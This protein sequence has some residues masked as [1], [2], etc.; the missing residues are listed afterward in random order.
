MRT[1]AGDSLT[2]I[3]ED[4]DDGSGYDDMGEPIPPDAPF[5]IWLHARH[6][7][8]SNSVGAWLLRSPEQAEQ[9]AAMLN[10]AARDARERRATTPDENAE[11]VTVTE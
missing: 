11:P 6:P 10:R 5:E 2:I 7:G 1:T 8:D 4:P 9:L 3:V